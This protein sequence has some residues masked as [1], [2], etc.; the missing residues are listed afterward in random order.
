MT[1]FYLVVQIESCQTDG[2][3]DCV[4]VQDC[5]LKKHSNKAFLNQK[6]SIY[7]K[8]LLC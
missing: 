7:K 4:L 6:K 5:R 8:L 1:K 3:V 2:V